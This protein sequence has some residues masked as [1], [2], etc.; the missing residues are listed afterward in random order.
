MSMR[1]KF[2]VSLLMGLGCFAGITAIIRTT[3]LQKLKT[4]TDVTWEV[5]TLVMWVAIECSVIIICACIPSLRPLFCKLLGESAGS[6][7]PSLRR[8]GRSE[9]SKNSYKLGPTPQSGDFQSQHGQVVKVFGKRGGSVAESQTSL[10]R[11]I[12]S[13]TEVEVESQPWDDRR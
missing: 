2:A 8:W 4:V 11:G 5:W 10:K 6:T 3:K 12:R 13:T 9:S 7:F 1:K